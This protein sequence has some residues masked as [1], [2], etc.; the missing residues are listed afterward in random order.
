[1]CRRDQAAERWGAE[2]RGAEARDWSLGGRAE[3]AELKGGRAEGAKPR[4][5]EPIGSC[6]K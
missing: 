3:W 2:Q 5:P 6:W 1:M 4:G